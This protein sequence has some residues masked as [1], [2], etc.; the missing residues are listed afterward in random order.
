[1][2]GPDGNEYTVSSLFKAIQTMGAQLKE[3]N[4]RVVAAESGR[5]K[6]KDKDGDKGGKKEPTPK[7]EDMDLERMSRKDFMGTIVKEVSEKVMRPL[8]E[9]ITENETTSQRDKVA[10][11]L[12]A[13]SEKDPDF[14]QFKEPVAKI[15]EEHPDLSIEDAYTLARSKDPEKVASLAKQAAEKKAAEADGDNGKKEPAFG[16][17]LPTSGQ[18]GKNESMDVKDAAQAA[19]DSTQMS[20]HLAAVAGE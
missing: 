3:A 4:A 8:L 2:K 15:L 16:G 6:S 9:R 10:G 14:W 5:G 17:L 12:K 7:V 18:G 20:A 1:M 13:V 11:E 19:W